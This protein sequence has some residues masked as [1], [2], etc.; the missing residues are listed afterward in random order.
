M[1][2]ECYGLAHGD[3]NAGKTVRRRI[4]PVDWDRIFQPVNRIIY[5]RIAT[6]D[7]KVKRALK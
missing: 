6:F 7:I 3:S 4:I 2:L 5:A 1:F